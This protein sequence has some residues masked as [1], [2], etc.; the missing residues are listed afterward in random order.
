MIQQGLN[1]QED[2]SREGAE[3]TADRKVLG[4]EEKGR[5]DDSTCPSEPPAEHRASTSVDGGRGSRQL[6]PTPTYATHGGR[7]SQAW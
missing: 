3:T 7:L 6:A 1:P 4:A 2:V 5:G